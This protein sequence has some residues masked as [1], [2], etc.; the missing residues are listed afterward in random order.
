MAHETTSDREQRLN[1]VMAAYVLDAELSRAPNRN[2]LLAQHPDIAAEMESFF[3]DYDRVDRLAQPL[4][5]AAR[6][7]QAA[8]VEAAELPRG[9]TTDGAESSDPDPTQPQYR[10][11]QAPAAGTHVRYFGDFELTGEIARGGMGVVYRARQLSLNRP[12]ALKMI[13]AGALASADDVL[14]FR[15]EAEA[16]ANLDHPNIVPVHEVGL[17]EGLTY[18]SMKLIDGASLAE[19]L[20]E[21]TSDPR[22]AA[23]LLATIARAVHHA[24]QRGVL[25]RDLKPSNILIDRQGQPHVSDFGLAKRVEADVELTR[26]GA[27]VGSPPY[28]APEQTTGRRGAITTA[29]DVYGLGAVLYAMLTGRPPFRADSV[30]ETIEQVRQ[31][32]PEPPSGINHRVARD[33]QTVCLKCLDKDPERRYGS[34]LELAED[35]DRW[36]DGRPIAAR[37]VGPTARAWLWCRRNRLV[38]GLSASLAVLAVLAILGSMIGIVVLR[39]QRDTARNLAAAVD[40]QRRKADARAHDARQAVDEMYTEVAQKWLDSQTGLEPVQRDFL[41]KALRFYDSFSREQGT[42]PAVRQAT[43]RAYRR[44]GDIR[45]RLGRHAEAETAYDQ[46]QSLLGPLALAAPDREDLLREQ[47]DILNNL[48][49]LRAKLGRVS[50]AETAYR[51]AVTLKE[52]LAARHPDNL[53]PRQSV[54]GSLGNLATLLASTGRMPEAVAEIR[55]ALAIQEELVHGAPGEKAK[56]K[57]S[58]TGL[59][60]LGVLYNNLGRMLKMQGHHAEAESE[61][62]R[63]VSSLEQAVAVDPRVTQYERDLAMSLN[64]LGTTLATTHSHTKAGE[65][66]QRAL[67]ISRKTVADAPSVPGHRMELA[68]SLQNLA[69]LNSNTDRNVEA[70]PF[71]NEALSVY[72]RLVADQPG[73]TEYAQAS[74]ENLDNFSATLFDLEEYRRAADLAER[75]SRLAPARG[76]VWRTL[77]MARYRL[78][79]WDGALLAL[80][81]ATKIKSTDGMTS[82]YLAMTYARKKRPALARDQFRRVVEQLDRSTPKDTSFDRL[83]DEAAALLG[84]TEGPT[85]KRE[86]VRPED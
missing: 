35:L 79:D 39:R 21:Y 17:H 71:F 56:W 64:G 81:K 51:R 65:A 5:E 23:K 83:R 2:E 38:A 47:A 80:E 27:V 4:R 25:H 54:V 76:R 68:R 62:R 49:V 10:I 50:E 6:A 57:P 3:R 9:S 1:E 46:A 40:T 37:R 55:R 53:E 78:G 33:L 74:F 48:G 77:G 61:F 70:I 84:L 30:L 8:V 43:A 15:N 34:A 82:F 45:L 24:H 13:L 85:S 16:A 14:R 31:R 44:V 60:R 73:V 19:R 86:T 42:D 67:A 36:L 12:V 22:A 28:M 66:F 69:A 59:N 26:S 72:D 11:S 63:A 58:A 20:S 75:A 52:Q 18:F 41:E 7:A 29:T 32:E